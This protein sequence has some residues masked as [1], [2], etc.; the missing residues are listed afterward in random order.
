M[1]EETELPVAQQESD[2]ERVLARNLGPWE[3][4][5]ALWG[6]TGKFAR[7]NASGVT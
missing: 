4:R 6:W 2:G 1:F 5:L 3:C 7:T